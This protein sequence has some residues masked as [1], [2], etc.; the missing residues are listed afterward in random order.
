[1]ARFSI[2]VTSASL[3][4]QGC[5]SAYRFTQTAIT[6]GHQISGVFF[7][8]SGVNIANTFQTMLSDELALYPK[9]VDLANEHKIPLQ[10]CVTAANRRGIISE[11]DAI[12]NDTPELFNLKPP[13][14]SVGIGELV[15]M[16]NE[17]DRS[18]QF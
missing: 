5:Y 6:N 12:Q 8:Q 16:L 9:W 15:S 13:F 10:V 7:Y 11:Q 18:I 14:Q 3:D 1:M 4:S 17:S 2:I